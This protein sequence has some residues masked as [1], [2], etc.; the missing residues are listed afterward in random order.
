MKLNK[1]HYGFGAVEVILILAVLGLV[2]FLGWR[3]YE[4]NKAPEVETANS[5]TSD[6]VPAIEKAEDL[7]A[8]AD[9][10]HNQKIDEALDTSEMDEALGQ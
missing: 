5:T 4:A 10:M 8:A 1:N 7:D 3:L 6:D 9:T 2:G